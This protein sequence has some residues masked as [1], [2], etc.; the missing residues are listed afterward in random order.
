MLR[1]HGRWRT[2]LREPFVEID[3]YQVCILQGDGPE[4]QSQKSL[5]LIGHIETSHEFQYAP[6]EFFS[7]AFGVDIS[8]AE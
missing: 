4:A 3:G 2:A 1:S 7:S 6:S 5:H 8:K